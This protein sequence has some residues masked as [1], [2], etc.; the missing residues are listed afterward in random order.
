MVVCEKC[1]G[2][3]GICECDGPILDMVC[4]RCGQ[5]FSCSNNCG[6]K[7]ECKFTCTCPDCN[8]DSDAEEYEDPDC[9]VGVS[10]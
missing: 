9:W 1:L 3:K 2:N 5:E 10:I 6:D 8:Y 4:T 7:G